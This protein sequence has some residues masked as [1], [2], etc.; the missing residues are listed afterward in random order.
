MANKQHRHLPFKLIDRDSKMLG[1][2]RIQAAGGL[3]ED[4][5]LRLL[6]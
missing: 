6:E 1:G 5:N 3:I 2:R 4:E